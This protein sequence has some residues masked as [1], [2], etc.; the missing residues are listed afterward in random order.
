MSV[1]DQSISTVYIQK[2]SSRSLPLALAIL[3]VFKPRLEPKTSVTAISKASVPLPDY[4]G[5][6]VDGLTR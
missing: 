3:I 5:Y 4:W 1:V 2:F 6:A